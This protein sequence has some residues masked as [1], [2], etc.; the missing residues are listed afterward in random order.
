[1]YTESTFSNIVYLQ[2]V[3][4]T[5]NSQCL[6]DHN[7]RPSL[8]FFPP[9]SVQ[10]LKLPV[11]IA[12]SLYD[13][14]QLENTIAGSAGSSRFWGDCLTNHSKCNSLQ[15]QSAQFL[16]SQLVADISA[17]TSQGNIDVWGTSCWEHTIFD[18]N[19]VW[20]KVA[21]QGVTWKDAIHS[22]L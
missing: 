3:S 15:T 5:L 18:V 12:N 10:Y 17:V 9:I 4:S 8:C 2:N 16:Y 19:L 1:M 7:Y 11:F 21:S 13:V 6:I 22:W 14:W 20:S